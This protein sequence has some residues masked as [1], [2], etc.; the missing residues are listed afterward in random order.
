[1]TAYEKVISNLNGNLDDNAKRQ[2]I[3]QALLCPETTE[4]E[5]L[6]LFSIFWV[7]RFID[8]ELLKQCIE[9]YVKK[10][11]IIHLFDPIGERANY[12]NLGFLEPL[13]LNVQNN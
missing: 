10:Q 6:H 5:I 11:N 8:F 7:A 3:A 13:K 2:D 12:M 4:A 1:M 9:Y